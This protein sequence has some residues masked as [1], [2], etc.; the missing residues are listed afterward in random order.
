MAAERA[1]GR[2]EMNIEIATTPGGVDTAKSI[3]SSRPRV[4]CTTYIR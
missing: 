3:S 1:A 2:C 4:I